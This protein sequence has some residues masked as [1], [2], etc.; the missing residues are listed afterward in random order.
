MI[1]LA[2]ALLLLF[3]GWASTIAFRS[4]KG[5]QNPSWLDLAAQRERS[6]VT[7]Q[8][9]V[10]RCEA[11]PTRPCTPPSEHEA[12]QKLYE[13]LRAGEVASALDL[14]EQ[15]MAADAGKSQ[16]RLLLAHALLV[17]GDLDAAESMHASASDL[18][19]ASAYA[20]YLACRI[21]L[22]AYLQSASDGTK[23][24]PTDL[25]NPI[26]L[27][28]LE[29][30]TK[31]GDKGDASALWLPGEGGEVP[32]EEARA[33]TLAHFSGYYR[34][35]QTM[36]DSVGDAEY[37]DGIYLVARLAL[38]CGFSKE[39]AALMLSI[40]SEMTE[41]YRSKSFSRDIAILR[42]EKQVAQE[43]QTKEGRRVIKLKVLN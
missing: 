6:L 16:A 32:K 1:Y 30:H 10:E 25:L 11:G 24:L 27:L 12:T 39:G 14:A 40:E 5:E 4:L 41:S 15:Q 3:V 7:L 38:K 2:S 36:L 23:N 21:E 34:L 33:F 42:G 13:L 26:E 9:F 31:L 35:L 8:G 19:D 37:A 43:E 22:A 20:V 29:L 17:K 18:G 28:A